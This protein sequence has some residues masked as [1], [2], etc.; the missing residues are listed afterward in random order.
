MSSY[1]RN[2]EFRV[3]PRSENRSGRY[4]LDGSTDIPIGA[5]VVYSGGAENGLGLQPVLLATGAQDAP[6]PGQGGI[7]VYEYGP[8]A[9]AGDDPFLTTYSDKDTVPA[10]DAV[11]VVNGDYVKVV[12]RNTTDETFLE[13]RSYTGRVMVAGLGATSIAVG[14]LLTPGAG[15]DDDGYYTETSTAAE[16]WLVVTKVDNDRSEVEARL[17][18]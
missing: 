1:G 7:A 11:Q 2:F 8:A 4:Y 12:L 3:P 18:F 16:G 14:D 13:T 10:G 6:R 17:A 15:N 9:Y 5:P